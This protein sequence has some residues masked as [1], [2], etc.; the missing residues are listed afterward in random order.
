M[1]KVSNYTFGMVHPAS[2]DFE[3]LISFQRGDHGDESPFDGSGGV[4][5]H[6]FAPKDGRLHLDADENWSFR[7]P[8]ATKFDLVGVVT[9]EIG[10]LLGLSTVRLVAIMY[11]YTNPGET[12]RALH[13]DDIAGLFLVFVKSGVRSLLL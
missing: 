1:E 12:K 9:H 8:G 4:L 11:A 10:H 6:A 13:S 5:A 3:L 2:P 7:P